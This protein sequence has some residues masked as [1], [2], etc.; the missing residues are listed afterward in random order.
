MINLG[1]N[2]TVDAPEQLKAKFPD[3]KIVVGENEIQLETW[4][5]KGN[6]SMVIDLD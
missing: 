4:L 5:R 1:K 6:V 2:G 3:D